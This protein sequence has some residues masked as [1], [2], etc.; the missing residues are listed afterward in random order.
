MG[1]DAAIDSEFERRAM[2]AGTIRSIHL[3][4]VPGGPFSTLRYTAAP[5]EKRSMVG[6]DFR[7]HQVVG[8]QKRHWA[9]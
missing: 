1:D 5:W 3:D 9:L 6:V 8:L 4:S 2:L 7:R